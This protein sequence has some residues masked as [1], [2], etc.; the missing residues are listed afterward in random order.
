[1][2]KL[3]QKETNRYAKQQINK[4]KQEGSLSPKSV[5]ALWNTVS[6]QEIKKIL[7]NNHTHERVYTSHLCGITGVCDQLFTPLTQLLLECLGIGSLHY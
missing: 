2:F 4:K 7:R 5:F 3:T 6:L 1:M